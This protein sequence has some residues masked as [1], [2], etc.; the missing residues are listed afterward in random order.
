MAKFKSSYNRGG[1]NVIVFR[2]SK[3]RFLKFDPEYLYNYAKEQYIQAVATLGEAA[4]QYAFERGYR[5]KLS[6][7]KHFVVFNSEGDPIWTWN[8]KRSEKGEG[9]YS[10][11][12]NLHDSIGSAVYVDGRLREDTIRF[13]D[14]ERWSKRADPR[15]GKGRDVLNDYFRFTAP[16]RRKDSIVLVMV[17]AMPYAQFLE[18]GTHAGGYEIQVI[19]EAVDYL[20][21]N[22][23]IIDAD[24]R[25]LLGM[26][27]PGSKLVLGDMSLL[28][29]V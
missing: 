19:S 14:D 13:V 5:G 7:R 22:W 23:R 9:W 12:G 17:A 25:E 15:F 24:V 26:D 6:P 20:E 10:R 28:E 3:G 11:L 29:Y 8:E 4:I 2:D 18:E 16:P 21:D 1:K 27:K